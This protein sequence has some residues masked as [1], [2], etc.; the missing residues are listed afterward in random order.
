MMSKFAKFH[1][2][3]R[4]RYR[5]KFI[6]T[7]AIELLEMDKF[8]I[9]L[10]TENQCKRPILVVD[11]TTFPSEFLIPFSHKKGSLYHDGEKSNQLGV[12]GGGGGDGVPPKSQILLFNMM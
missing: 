11:L 9:Q 6:P 12:C 3:I 7:S 8:C 2:D 5:Q 1:A 4:S 10:C